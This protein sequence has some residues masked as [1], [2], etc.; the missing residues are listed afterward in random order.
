MC[1][2]AHPILACDEERCG[3]EVEELMVMLADSKKC[4]ETGLDFVMDFKSRHT[5]QGERC[6]SFFLHFSLTSTY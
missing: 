6:T 2:I 4:I 1:F 5:A 3:T